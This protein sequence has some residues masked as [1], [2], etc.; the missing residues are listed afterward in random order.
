MN[1]KKINQ[2]I[3]N[4]EGIASIMDKEDVAYNNIECVNWEKQF[5]YKPEVKFRIAYTDEAILLDY[6]VT[7][8]TARAVADH[9]GGNVWEDS[10]VEFF[11]KPEDSKYYYN[12]ECNC[13][14]TLLVAKGENRNDRTQLL[15]EEMIK[16]KRFSTL[17][18][19]PFDEKKLSEPWRLSLLIPFSIL[20]IDS[21]ESNHF[22]ANFYKCGDCLTTPHFLS[23]APINVPTPNFHLPEFF[24]PLTFE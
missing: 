19:E 6:V 4:P 8:D 10:C 20:G 11:I 15:P 2:H 12:I 14:G 1:V 17:G 21:P 7:E 18:R 9:D 13:A 3:A 5:P 24:A 16:V 22:R 23:W